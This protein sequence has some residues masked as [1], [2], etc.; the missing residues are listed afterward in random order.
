MRI[1]SFQIVNYKSYQDSGEIELSPGFN[2]LVGQNNAGK[3]TLLEALTL[4]FPAKPHKSLAVLPRS[5]A[6]T[7]PI[8]SATVVF[9][10]TSEEFKDILLGITGGFYVPVP[11]DL[12]GQGTQKFRD[13][14]A[15][16]LAPQSIDLCVSLVS[17]PNQTAAFRADRLPTHGLYTT[18]MD[19]PG[20]AMFYVVTPNDDR[21]DFVCAQEVSGEA[22][23]DF[24]LTT[25]LYLRDRI[26]SFI[27]Q[28]F[29]LGRCSVGAGKVLRSDASNLAEV[30]STLQ[31]TNPSLFARFNQYVKEI[32][33][34]IFQVS[35]RNVENTHLEVIVWTENPLSERGDLAVPLDECGT[36]VGQVL[37]ILYVVLT[38]QFSRTILIDEPNSFLH[39]AATR[40][41]VEILKID[42]PMHQYIVATHSPEVIKAA[43]PNS[44]FMVRLE[45]RASRLDRLDSKDVRDQGRCLLEVGARLSDVFG[46][47]EIVW[48]E[49][50]TEEACFRLIVRDLLKRP[51]LG[52]TIIAV[53]N[54]GDFEGKRRSAKIIWDIYSQLTKSNALIPPAIAFVFDREQRSEAERNDLT[55]RS[56]GKLKFLPR[57]MYENYLLAPEALT[58]VL[59]TLSSFQGGALTVDRVREWLE[60]NGG[61]RPYLDKPIERID[62]TNQSWLED[63]N[64]AKLLN[65]LFASLSENREEYRKTVHSVQLTE[66]LIE[67][68][69]AALNEIKH[70]LA[71]ILET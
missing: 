60:A 24:G 47:D 40:K 65:D 50:D 39:P 11:A 21:S 71:S 58:T 30:L 45:G 6:S 20:R 69:P 25:C 28:R 55:Q 61:K 43:E 49:G 22:N 7:N 18:Q 9:S 63:V 17:S 59:L 27:A 5:T 12:R 46:S 19:S 66:W 42:F 41:L 54:V 23:S 53:R 48:V 44:L 15:R 70:L 68:K 13:V 31:G 29:N 38:S 67:N 3:S 62:V 33:P 52:R 10:L 57:R 34:T 56:G 4:T 64:G 8:S 1:S 35:V 36:G 16:T 51:L 14:L 26:Y 32:F 37:A 2:V